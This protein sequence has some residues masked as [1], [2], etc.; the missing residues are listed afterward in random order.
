M[1]RG[2]GPRPTYKCDYETYR[3]RP[4]KTGARSEEKRE[5]I[6]GEGSPCRVGLGFAAAMVGR[7]R[8]DE[9]DEARASGE[10]ASGM[11]SGGGQ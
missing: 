9:E 5:G 2:K 4:G 1:E 8:K 6:I 7:E 11:L 3:R 10:A